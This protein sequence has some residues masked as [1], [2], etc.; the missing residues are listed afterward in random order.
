MAT[1]SLRRHGA[2][3]PRL[4]GPLVRTPI[5]AA[6]ARDRRWLVS[7]ALGIY[8]LG[9]TWTWEFP[10]WQG[11]PF[12]PVWLG[13]A[14]ATLWAWRAVGRELSPIPAA[15]IVA[16]T[17]MLTTDVTLFWSQPLRDLM[18]YLKAGD[19]WVSGAPVYATVPL[20]EKPDD[21]S[22]YPFLYPPVTLPL[23]AALAAVPFPITAV[24]WLGV[25][26]A[27]VVGGLRAIGL[28]WRWCLLFL[29]WPP[30]AQGLYVGN[31]AVPLFALFAF[32]VW[33]PA[34]LVLPPIF[35]LYSGIASLWL[36]RRE[37]WRDL[38]VGGALVLGAGLATLPLTGIDLWARWVEGLRVYQ[39]SQQ[40][41]PEYLYG[42]GLGRYAPLVLVAVLAVV[43]TLLALRARDRRDQLA[44]LG[45]ATVVGS[46]SLFSHGWLVVVPALTR[47]ATPWYWLA[48]GLTACSPGIAWFMTLM[49]V[50]G[51][52]F[53]PALRRTEGS[54][55][56]HPLGSAAEPWPE[57]GVPPHERTGHAGVTTATTGLT[58]SNPAP[59]LTN[60]R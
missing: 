15:A 54:E 21:L 60:V 27:A 50:A 49:I 44:R 35:K 10:N 5:V 11:V 55:A 9:T 23:F 56:W 58:P 8:V 39:V 38:A 16:V 57:P 33:R 19:A 4:P 34:M 59:T 20:V 46:P 13:A 18:L 36:L 45:V 32:A 40:L 28:G 37:H 53:L 43:V 3:G 26:V 1:I 41:L 14:V 25:S 48:F 31:V 52:W 42:F 47:L 30:V 2:G 7:L 6:V 29:A 17:A 24:L 12:P 22:N 51:S